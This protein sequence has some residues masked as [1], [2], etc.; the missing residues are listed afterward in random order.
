MKK[1]STAS[2]ILRR[3]YRHDTEYNE[4]L[5]EQRI[6]ARVS[7][8]IF[9][10]RTAAGLSQQE[11]ADRIGT[12]Q[13]AIARLEDGDYDRHSV[14]MLQRIADALDLKL[15]VRFEVTQTVE[16]N[17]I[18]TVETIRDIVR[19][20]LARCLPTIIGEIRSASARTSRQLAAQVSNLYRIA[21]SASS[22]NTNADTNNLTH[23]S[24]S[25]NIH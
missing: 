15:S 7:Q 25:A 16:E 14:A 4:L 22:G 6:V 8:A 10:A 20:E 19:D 5:A 23:A 13:P 2:A 24:I 21:E 12:S 11:L 18:D 9:E 1:N 3:R 17:N